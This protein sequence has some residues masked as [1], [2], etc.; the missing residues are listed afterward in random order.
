MPEPKYD[1]IVS[2]VHLKKC[3]LWPGS[4]EELSFTYGGLRRSR[5]VHKIGL[6][7]ACDDLQPDEVEYLNALRKTLED[8]D[9][10]T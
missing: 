2:C 3:K 6:A 1:R 4:H 9:A 10:G 7:E 5:V 8:C